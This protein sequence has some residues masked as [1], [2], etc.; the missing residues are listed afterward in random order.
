MALKILSSPSD[1]SATSEQLRSAIEAAL[2]G[3]RAEVRAAGAGH[4]EITVVWADFAGRSKLA[5][6]QT[7]Y[8]AITPFLSGDGAPVHAIDRLDCR[9]A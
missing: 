9:P 8:R 5:Q 7:V 3:A 6:H 4:F 2:A 1:P